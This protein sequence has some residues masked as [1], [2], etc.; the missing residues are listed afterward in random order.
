VAPFAW[1]FESD[2][3]DSLISFT[4]GI[5]VIRGGTLDLTFA[6]EV[7]PATQYGRTF[8]IFD[9]TGVNPTGTFTVTSPLLLGPVTALHHRKHH[10]DCGTRN[11][12]RLCL[13]PWGLLACSLVEATGRFD[14]AL[15]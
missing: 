3:W 8:H 2:D 10:A 13:Q 5:P 7:D 9:W 1:F 4:P 14:P 12:R 15:W 11:P 6:P